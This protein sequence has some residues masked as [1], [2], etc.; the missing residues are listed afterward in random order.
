MSRQL[1]IMVAFGVLIVL[2]AGGLRQSFGVFLLPVTTD[3]QIGR[4]V[5]GLVIAIQALVYGLAQP[6]VG[7][8]ADRIGAVKVVIAGAVFYAGGLWLTSAAQSSAGLLIS[9][10]VIV[11]L[12]LSGATQVV[13]LGAVGK[14][15]PDN[16]RS[17]VF[18]T[19]IASSSLG[20]FFI[21]PGAQRLLSAFEWRDTM[22]MFAATLAL[23]PL[24]A[25]GLR[26]K[27]ASTVKQSSQSLSHALVEARSHS[28]YVFLTLGF[29]VCGFHVTFVGTHLPAFLTDEGVS[30]TAA[31]YALGLVGLCNVAGAYLFGALGDRFSKKNLLT[32]I[33]TGRAV[34]MALVLVVPINDVT[35]LIFGCLMGLLWLATVPLTSS[36]VA[37]VF[38]TK[39]FSMLFG[40]VMMSHQF[41]SF[42]G[43][44]L[45]G[46]IHDRTGSYDQMWVA[47]V[48]LA[49]LAAALHWPIREA[50]L[51][52]L[53]TASAP[54]T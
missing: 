14:V 1:W 31:A 2:I 30:E 8:I 48:V 21:V 51:A 29:F 20:M 22:L 49:L 43:A 37:Q 33:Y 45:G 5:F 44:W 3:L 46:Y 47:S 42:L 52:R 25:V 24:L 12:G 10:G 16:K 41:G 7:L 17:I 35:A 23:V 53:A 34:L 26:H 40:V 27:M 9:L 18:G 15:V 19:V 28:G 4:E 32:C 36:I 6:I 11:G 13:V 38:G 54:G 50:P 39:Y